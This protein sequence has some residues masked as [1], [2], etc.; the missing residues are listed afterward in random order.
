MLEAEV[1]FVDKIEEVCDLVEK[2]IGYIV[3]FLRTDSSLMSQ[4]EKLQKNFCSE[5]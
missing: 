2:Y 4:Y 5:V 1:G 3:N